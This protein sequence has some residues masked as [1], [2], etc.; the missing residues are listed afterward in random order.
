MLH[1]SRALSCFFLLACLPLTGCPKAGPTVACVDV[2][3]VMSQS[4]ASQQANEHLSQVQAVLQN[5][6]NAYQAQ[7]KNKPGNRQQQELQQ[8]V[9]VLQRQMALE[10]AAA[11]NIVSQHM[12]KQIENW[13]A[14]KGDV[15]VIARQNL[16]AATASLDISDEIITRMDAGTVTFPEL[17]KVNSRANGKTTPNT[18][19]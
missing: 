11:R 15:V 17:P 5:S 18:K 8:G 9:A 4:K 12:L 16:L 6:L 14:G 13:R 7:L 10:Q 19:K 1:F 2:E 3:R